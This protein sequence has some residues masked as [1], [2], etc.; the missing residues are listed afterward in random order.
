MEKGKQVLAEKKSE[1]NIRLDEN[2]IFTGFREF[3]VAQRMATA[4]ASSTI[5]PKDYQNNPGNCLI[6]LEMA[7]RLKT[8]PM[9]VM[10]NLYVVNGRPAWSSQ[11]IVAMIT[12]SRKYKTELQYEMKGSRT[13]GSLEC[14]AWVEDYNGHRVTGPTVTMKMAQ[15][16]GWIGRNGSKWKTMPEVM[17]RYRAASFFGRLNCPDMIMGIYSE[18]EAIELEPSQFE[19]VDQVK[20]AEQE[21]KDNVGRQ[22]IDVDVHTGEVITKPA[23]QTQV[24][25]ESGEPDLETQMSIEEPDF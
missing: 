15:E 1:E 18:E 25:E 7:N 10:Q 23:A 22:D 14:T 2:N 12:S 16:E 9:M 4:L 11:Y 24:E 5:V 20:A 17:I 8:S 6:A 3:Q 19:F 13:D 21:I